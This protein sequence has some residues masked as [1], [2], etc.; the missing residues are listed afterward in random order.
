MS[1]KLRKLSVV[2]DQD[3]AAFRAR[4]APLAS[5]VLPPSAV[6]PPDAQCGEAGAVSASHFGLA[7]AWPRWWAP[8]GWGLSGAGPMGSIRRAT[9]GARRWPGR[10]PGQRSRRPRLRRCRRTRC[11]LGWLHGPWAWRPWT[12]QPGWIWRWPCRHQDPAVVETTNAASATDKVSA[13]GRSRFRTRPI[14]LSGW[15]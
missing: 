12:P 7:L 14:T 8:C 5:E 11:R 4:L 3:D 13:R 6:A 2:D 10:H 9:R 1:G 15:C